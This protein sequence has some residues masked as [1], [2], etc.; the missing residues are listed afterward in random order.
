MLSPSVT[1]VRTPLSSFGGSGAVTKGTRA[2]TSAI[3]PF[4][5]DDLWS[6]GG[7]RVRPA[8]VEADGQ[9]CVISAGA[10]NPVLINVVR[11]AF[12]RSH[13]TG[14]QHRACRAHSHNLRDSRSI[15]Y[16]T[17]CNDRAAA[18]ATDHFGQESHKL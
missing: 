11:P 12:D 10:R 2:R 4:L 5:S 13:E 9:R 3:I 18:A 8:G 1:I 17:G 16:P 15:R 6:S 7:N 14:P